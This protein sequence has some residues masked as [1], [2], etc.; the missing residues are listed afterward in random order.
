MG[1]P[2]EIAEAG[3]RLETKGL[4]PMT[5]SVRGW[6]PP[7][8]DEDIY[9]VRAD[10]GAIITARPRWASALGQLSSPM[11]GVFDEQVRQLGRRVDRLVHLRQLRGGHCAFLHEAGVLCVGV[12]IERAVFNVELLDKCAQAY[13]L[14]WSTGRRVRTIPLWVR[15][16]AFH[17]LKKDQRRATLAWARGDEPTGFTA[18]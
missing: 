14:A 4:A 18:Y 10:V 6:S 12:T 17:R 11:P 16:I 15:E 1:V 7:P 8:F 13:L 2:E 3:R 5:V 9:R